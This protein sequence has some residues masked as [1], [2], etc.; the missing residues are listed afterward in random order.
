M[1]NKLYQLGQEACLKCPIQLSLIKMWVKQIT[2]D[3][4]STVVPVD[5]C[6]QLH[7]L[8]PLCPTVQKIK[9]N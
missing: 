9:K 2:K 3:K 1:T 8:E 4:Q 6:Y 5:I 7:Q